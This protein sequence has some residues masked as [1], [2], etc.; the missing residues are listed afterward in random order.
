MDKFLL[1]V[2]APAVAGVSL[3]G[4]GRL[5]RR[6]ARTGPW[7]IMLTVAVGLAAVLFV[8]GLLNVA[9][10]ARRPAIDAVVIAGLALTFA[11]WWKSKG[12]TSLPVTRTALLAAVPVVAVGCFLAVHLLPQAAFNLHDDFE[13]YM[14]HPVEMLATGAMAANPLDSLGAETLGGQAFL[15]AFVAAHFPLTYLGA[16]DGFFC[17][18]LSV[19][20]VGF[21]VRPGRWA[22]GALAAELC[23]LAINPQVVNLSSL[24]SGVSLITAAVLITGLP[25]ANGTKTPSAPVLGLVYAGL[26]SLKGTLAVFVGIHLL[27][28]VVIGLIL[29]RPQL[30]WML[31]VGGW[32]M[33]FVAPWIILHAP[34]YLLP[35]LAAPVVPPGIPA[36]PVDFFSTAPL[37]WGATQ[38]DYSGLA[39]AGL[40]MAGTLL[41]AA[42]RGWLPVSTPLLAVAAAGL[43]AMLTYFVTVAFI[44]PLITKNPGGLRYAS[45]ALIGA[46]PVS[47]RLLETA[48]E[49]R[50]WSR[51]LPVCL[52]GFGLIVVFAF[53]PSSLERIDRLMQLRTPLSFLS[54]RA[55]EDQAAYL[56]YSQEVLAGPRQSRLTHVQGMV[57][58]GEK[59][60]AWVMTPFWLDFRRNPIAH[61]N[62]AGLGMRW[63]R[64]PP[65]AYYLLLEHTGYA[66]RPDEF[67]LRQLTAACLTDRVIAVRSM[68]FLRTI[69][70]CANR[71]DLLYRDDSYVLFRIRPPAPDAA[72]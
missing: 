36:E 25:D 49:G 58:P 19:S 9:H 60:V 21:G 28:V 14:A 56:K 18:L 40:F 69:N 45:A 41:L 43:A 53:L 27:S 23:V 13:K 8:G 50:R 52:A 17:L 72:P 71:S 6:L 48:T 15:H 44:G 66:V 38:L 61:A 42:R 5:V 67:Y 24:F 39:L 62:L 10:L 65:D 2:T 12:R 1:V 31:V 20:L 7:T 57:P 32:T 34:L 68:A 22:A 55:R 26:I 4:W 51:H 47:L 33:I 11:S 29:G 16:V 46:I 54:S 3:W 35:P 64:F 63:A 59:I 70:E 37:Y 30:K